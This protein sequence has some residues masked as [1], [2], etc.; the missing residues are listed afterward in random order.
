[1]S[2]GY[3]AGISFSGFG[4]DGT[5]A[6]AMTEGG[7]AGASRWRYI[8]RRFACSQWILC[9]NTCPFLSSTK[10]GV[11]LNGN[12]D[13]IVVNS[14]FAVTVNWTCRYQH[15]TRAGCK[16]TAHWHRRQEK[17]CDG[18]RTFGEVWDTR[19]TFCWMHSNEYS[20]M[21]ALGSL[22]T[23]PQSL[24]IDNTG[25]GALD[26]LFLK[27]N[28]TPGHLKQGKLVCRFFCFWWC[29]CCKVVKLP[30]DHN[31]KNTSEW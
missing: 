29:F 2:T 24:S 17:L 19:P 11:L 6:T 14:L 27:T 9:K 28:V 20:S 1:M 18:F 5:S 13:I 25:I 22:S 4:A 15:S 16:S 30:F 10:K 12:V 7:S 31:K 8:V 23:F 21:V 3:G 26:W